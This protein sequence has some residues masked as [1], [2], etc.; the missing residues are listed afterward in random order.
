MTA[1][2][3]GG[4]DIAMKVPPHQFEATVAFYRDTIGLK[5][6]EAKA[7]AIG[8]EFGPCKLWIDETASASHAEVWLEFFTPDFDAAAAH[9]E[10]SGVTRCDPIERLPDGFR[11]G[12]VMN[13]ANIVHMLREPDAW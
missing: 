4:I 5:P 8:F 3:E 1:R 2:I 10:K 13:P 6:I 12:W 11:G 9:L 7:P